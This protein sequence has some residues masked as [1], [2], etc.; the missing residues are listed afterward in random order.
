MSLN[1]VKSIEQYPLDL[2]TSDNSI[3]SH[4]FDKMT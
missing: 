4:T 3:L 1:G 2:H